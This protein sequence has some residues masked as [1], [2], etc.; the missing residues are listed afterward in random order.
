MQPFNKCVNYIL[1]CGSGVLFYKNINIEKR[2]HPHPGLRLGHNMQLLWGLP[3]TNVQALQGWCSHE[4]THTVYIQY[5][6]ATV[7]SPHHPPIGCNAIIPGELHQYRED[8]EKDCRPLPHTHTHKGLL[9]HTYTWEQDKNTVLTS[10]L[11]RCEGAEQNNPLQGRSSKTLCVRMCRCVLV[12]VWD[13]ELSVL[14]N[15]CHKLLIETIK[16]MS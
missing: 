5:S 7:S 15:L 12:C 2:L 6:S 9:T 14:N 1:A 8:T 10:Q 16:E 4:S 13:R 3:T 11:I